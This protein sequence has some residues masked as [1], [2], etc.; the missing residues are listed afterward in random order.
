[1]NC[2]PIRYL[3]SIARPH[4][5]GAPSSHSIAQPQIS[6]A[7]WCGHDDPCAGARRRCE[8][9]CDQCGCSV[10]AL[11]SG[12]LSRFVGEDRAHGL[13]EPDGMAAE[14]RVLGMYRRNRRTT[15]HVSKQR[16]S[17]T[18]GSVLSD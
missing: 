10:R 9:L 11:R 2:A 12:G 6:L 3:T 4:R 17:L 1:M 14:G 5:G 7:I 15:G 18:T 13:V 8:G 16:R